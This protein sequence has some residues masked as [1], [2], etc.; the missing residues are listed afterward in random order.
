MPALTALSTVAEF[1]EVLER[2]QLLKS[3]HV[4]RVREQSTT[5]CDGEPTPE[6]LAKSLIKSQIVTLYQAQRLLAG[7]A[8]GFYLGK[9]KIME[10]LGR[11]GMGKVYLAEQI[12]MNRLVAIKVISKFS[13]NRD[14]TL[15]RFAREAKAVAA[16]QHANIIQAFDFDQIDGLPYIVMEYVEGVDLG[17]IAMQSGR[18]DWA[19]A[20]D[21][22]YQAALGLEAARKAEFVHRDIK[23]G[24][25]LVDRDGILKILDLGLA[26]S[27]DEQNNDSLTSANDQ[28]GTVDF[29]SPEQALDSHNVD[30]RSDIYSLGGVMYFAI[31]GHLPCP[32][33]NSAAKLVA[34]QQSTPKPIKEFVPDIPQNLALIIQGMLAKKRTERPQTPAAVAELL[35]PFAKRRSPPY[36]LKLIKHSRESL[37]PLLGRSPD[38][39]TINI[40]GQ[41]A[42]V[43]SP[44]R[45]NG[46]SSASRISGGS[47]SGKSDVL[48]ANTRRPGQINLKS[49]QITARGSG[50]TVSQMPIA[51]PDT[52]A[53]V[54]PVNALV[55][56]QPSAVRNRPAPSVITGM[57]ARLSPTTIK[58]K[59][60]QSTILVIPDAPP[61]SD[62]DDF[63]DALAE[64]PLMRPVK[65]L[66]K[67][68]KKS[69][70]RLPLLIG[71]ATIAM[72]LVGFL[73]W[74]LIPSGS[75]LS[76]A[77]VT[78]ELPP[79]SFEN[80]QAWSNQF[81][82][83]PD[84][85]F[86]FT[87]SG[88][89][90]RGD[91]VRSQAAKPKYSQVTA[92]VYGAKYA[93]GRFP[94]K[95][96]LKFGGNA[97]KNYVALGDSDSNL[98]NFTTSFSVGAW[99]KMQGSKSIF[100][101]VISK[102]DSVWRLQRYQTEDKLELGTNNSW[103]D[104]VT[105]EVK[106]K[107]TFNTSLTSIDD[108]KWHFAVAVYD[109]SGK[110]AV[111]QLYVDGRVEGVAEFG[112]LNKNDFPV[113]IGANSQ[114]FKGDPRVWS[115]LIDEVFV[116]NRALTAAEITRIHVAGRPP[117]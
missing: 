45:G 8:E 20:A 99:F 80:W 91:V 26:V 109:L 66:G 61:P 64:T 70:L 15:A 33:K 106:G 1:L 44:V 3:G 76:A 25:L 6:L 105:K 58:K 54:A 29:M 40:S 77:N 31:T 87:F 93:S 74:V 84:L 107:L 38:L 57:P 42:G 48:Q 114:T 60:P 22:G 86:Y 63:L 43:T 100:Q 7:M 117:Q 18:L 90:D 23:P 37:A 88:D 97:S 72:L 4:A 16:L 14:D 24:N 101:N 98:C 47:G 115:G 41:S 102:G 21:F 46:G 96:G 92:K 28:I 36:D 9:Y 104:P 68:R 17:E 2:S 65:R 27:R 67:K 95:Q 94:E 19:T 49:T 10:L 35:K 62:D 51:K 53:A 103:H 59:S 11:G 108:Q 81:K 34:H 32:G 39:E 89:G 113:Y 116:I 73:I 50:S 111:Q 30:C 83:D 69:G 5:I 12:T 75:D 112:S 85:I 78:R 82:Q 79:P 56:R 71:L 52:V 110:K 13:K 55:L